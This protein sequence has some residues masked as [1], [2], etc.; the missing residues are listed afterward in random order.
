KAINRRLVTHVHLHGIEVWNR[1]SALQRMA[2][3]RSDWIVSVSHYSLQ[4]MREVQGVEPRHSAV[5]HAPLDPSFVAAPVEF[6]DALAAIRDKR[7]LLTVA[8]LAT[9]EKFKGVR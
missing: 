7:F 6:D 5:M 2:L 8:R 3:R 9:T 1:R 4:R